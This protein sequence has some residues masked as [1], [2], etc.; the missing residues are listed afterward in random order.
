MLPPLLLLLLLRLLLP[1]AAAAAE[2]EQLSCLFGRCCRLALQSRVY[3]FFPETPPSQLEHL[4]QLHSLESLL[5]AIAG[6]GPGGPSGGLHGGEPLA[7][8]WCV[9][10]TIPRD[11]FSKV[12]GE[13]LRCR[14]SAIDGRV[15]PRTGELLLVVSHRWEFRI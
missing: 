5:S 3:S 2:L 15:L 9:R 10:E 4:L 1:L 11:R 6:G 12:L 7:C 13:A 14:E 8:N